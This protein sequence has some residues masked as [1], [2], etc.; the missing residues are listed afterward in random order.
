MRKTEKDG[1]VCP[2]Y[3]QNS[4]EFRIDGMQQVSSSYSGITAKKRR[5]LLAT[6]AIYS[7]NSVRAIIGPI[8][9]L[10]SESLNRYSLRV[11]WVDL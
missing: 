4:G 2:G 11:I 7:S 5:S 6:R 3:G 9:D 8:L 10:T 1:T